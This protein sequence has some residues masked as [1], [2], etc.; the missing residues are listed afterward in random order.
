MKTRLAA[1]AMILV[2]VGAVALAIVGPS[3][4]G[5]S[6]AKYITGTATTGS[7]TA[8]S[9]ATGTIAASTVYGFK[10]GSAPDIVSTSA[11]TSGSGGQVSGASNG[12]TGNLTWPVKTV[13]VT[14]GQSV[15]K[16][17]VLATADDT[18]A[19]LQLTSA[20]ATLASAQAR[21]ASDQAGAD[22]LTRAQANLQL[23]QAQLSYSQAAASRKTTIAQNA[24][25]VATAKKAVTDAQAKLAADTPGTAQY[26]ADVAALAKAQSDYSSAVLKANQ[27]NQ[28]ATQQVQNASLSLSGARLSY[29]GKVAPA[30][31]ATILADQAQVA[32][33][34][35][36][37]DAAQTAVNAA[38]ITAPA[39]GLIVAVNILP[40]V[41]APSGY[42][43]E[44][45][46]TPMVAT[47][48]FSE[49]DISNLKVG[50]VATV[51][52]TA[53]ST[54]VQGT[55]SQI[56]PVSS[57]SSSGG[58]GQQSSVV[59]YTVIVTLTDPPAT[60]LAGMTATVSVTT[61]SVDNAVRVPS[62]ALSGSA[63]TGYTVQVMGSDG[64]VSTRTVEVGLITTSMAQIK[65]G[66]TEGETVV[67]GTTSTR[68]GT[69]TTQ[70]GGLGGLTGGGLTGGGFTGP[71][72]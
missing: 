66:L 59:S 32:S 40:G 54:S 20:Q 31:S 72:R 48:S 16:G 44:E 36:S 52:V 61:A 67:T 28:Q 39:D 21:L 43:I 4:A 23:K 49:T 10:F 56:T 35:T 14:V 13:S 9:V 65:S 70:N 37:V 50:Q 12:S 25:T 57:S 18:A 15:K 71:G 42:A 46:V 8:T 29:Q 55:V 33:A 69:T 1:L 27:S 38:A 19:L 22:A 63:S 17:D 30:S 60:V 2:G 47:A 6:S 24:A 26:D 68:S 11:T 51:G 64:S 34:Q 3:F 5:S 53:A 45:S 62:T 7:V 41:N 58:V